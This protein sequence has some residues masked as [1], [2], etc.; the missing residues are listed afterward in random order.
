MVFFIKKVYFKNR[1][2]EAD[3]LQIMQYEKIDRIKQR[4][5]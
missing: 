5:E 2:I 1:L 4:Q 3:F